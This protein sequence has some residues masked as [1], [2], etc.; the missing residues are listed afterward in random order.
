LIVA[1]FDPP[2]FCARIVPP[3]KRTNVQKLALDLRVARG[4]I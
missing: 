1:G 4:G 2:G 3:G